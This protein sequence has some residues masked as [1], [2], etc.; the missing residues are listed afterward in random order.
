MRA[1]QKNAGAA[2]G[3]KRPRSTLFGLRWVPVPLAVLATVVGWLV[4][5]SLQG[6]AAAHAPHEHGYQ[7]GG[8]ALNVEQ[9]VWMSNDMSGEGPLKVPKGFSMDPNM[10]P[11]MQKEGDNRLR[12]EVDLRNA[13]T[14]V[15][16]YALSDFRAVAPG[17]RSWKSYTSAENN[18]PGS[19]L[20]EPGFQATI[21]VYFDIPAKQSKNLSIEWSRGGTTVE[22][23]VNTSG[24]PSM[25]GMHM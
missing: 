23:P 12:V 24:T 20:L 16:R 7:A 2:N 4:V 13:G 9:M 3:L 6:Q 11:G 10:M 22:I 25:Q 21:D 19:A 14:G 8:L 5:G 17:G 15:Q 18:V 1:V